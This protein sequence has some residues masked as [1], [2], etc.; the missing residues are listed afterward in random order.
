MKFLVSMIFCYILRRTCLTASIP[1]LNKIVILVSRIFLV[2]FSMHKTLA[3]SWSKDD[4]NLIMSTL[5]PRQLV[6]LAAAIP[7]K[8]M[9][10]IAEGYLGIDPARIQN[11]KYENYGN[12]EA[13]NRQILRDWAYKN[14]TN[15]LQVF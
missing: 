6:L 8:E 3:F 5:T 14:N 11:I 13:I 4:W 10:T 9:F 15:Q 7:V 1:S 2:H 12:A